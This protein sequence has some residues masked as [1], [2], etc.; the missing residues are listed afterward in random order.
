MANPFNLNVNPYFQDFND[1]DDYYQ[2]LFRPGRPIQ[3]RELNNLQYG[4]QNQI[5]SLVSANYKEGQVVVPG[6]TTYNQYYTCVQIQNNFFGIPI[7]N[8]IDQL[9]GK[10]ISG[11]SSKITA[12][13]LYVL[14]ESE[15]I[16]KNYTL[17]LQYISASSNNFS[18]RTFDDNET[19]SLV[20]ETIRYGNVTINANTPLA[21]T[22]TSQSSA[23]GSS[24]SINDGVF[25]VRNYLVRAS[26]QTILL[27]QYSNFPS[28]RIGFSVQERIVTYSEDDNLVDNALGFNNYNAPG[29]DRL[30]IN[31]TLTK[32][33]LDDFNDVSFVELA[34]VVNGVLQKLEVLEVAPWRDELA[35]RTYDESGNY[36]VKSFT[37][38]ANESVNDLTGNNGIYLP[39]QITSSGEVPSDN[40]FVYNI[41][42][43]KAYVEGYEVTK[44]ESTYLDSF[45][46]RSTNTIDEITVPFQYD[47]SLT[48]NNIDGTIPINNQSAIVEIYAERKGTVGLTTVGLGKVYDISYAN[49]YTNESSNAYIDF[50]DLQLFTFITVNQNPDLTSQTAYVTG[51][52]SGASGYLY[53]KNINTKQ[54][55]LYQTSGKFLIGESL[56]IDGVSNSRDGKI[57]NLVITDLDEYNISRIKSIRY[58][59][60][61]TG[62]FSADFLLNI[63][64]IPISLTTQYT[65]TPVSATTATITA[66]GN[67]FAAQ[68]L[69]GDIVSYSQPGNI[70]P[71]YNVVI[72]VNNLANQV[73]VANVTSVPNVCIGTVPSTLLVVNDFKV[74]RTT[75]TSDYPVLWAQLP[76]QYVKEL[77]TT[78]SVVY[79]KYQTI[80]NVV[81]GSLSISAPSNKT[82]S[83]FDPLSYS[84]TYSDG[85]NEI[86][87]P[88][89]TRVSADGLLLTF[90][91]L[92]KQSATNVLINSVV[93]NTA[94]VSKTKTLI[95]SNKI[96]VDG[97]NVTNDTTESLNLTFKS[98]FGTRIQD[99]LI[100]LN[101][102]DVLKIRGI[103]ESID[104]NDPILPSI[105]LSSLSTDIN[106]III[107]EQFRGETSLSVATV[108][109][110]DPINQRVYFTFDNDNTFIVG[111]LIGFYESSVIATINA[112][113]DGSSNIT[114]NFTFDNGQTATI[115]N[116]SKIIRKDNSPVPTNKILIVFDNYIINPNIEGSF[117]SV[118]SYEG[119]NYGTQIPTITTGRLTDIID[120]R[121]RVSPYTYNVLNQRSPFEFLART[122]STSTNS[123]SQII[124]AGES[125]VV[126]LTYYLG[127][128]DAIYLDTNGLFQIKVGTPSDTPTPPLPL[129]NAINL[130]TITLPPYLTNARE[131]SIEVS[132]YR[133][134]QMRDISRLET[135][136]SNLEY[137]TNLSLLESTTLS[138]TIKDPLTGLDRFKSGFF[139]DNFRSHDVQ[140][141][142]NVEFRA[143]SD[144]LDGTLRPS[145][146]TTAID[147]V[148]GSNSIL[149]IG[150]IPASQV[151][152]SV[153][154][155]DLIGTNI[156]KTGDLLTLSY[157]E[158]LFAQNLFAT[159]VENV[160]PFLVVDY[161]GEVVL[162]PNSD[163]WI[164]TTA[165]QPNDI[166]LE[167]DYQALLDQFGADAQTGWAPIDWKSWETN[168]VGVNVSA[169]SSTETSSSSSS[170]NTGTGTLNSTTQTSVTTSTVSVGVDLGQTR[171]GTQTRITP[172]IETADL[173]NRVVSRDLIPFMRSRNLQFTCKGMKP[174]TQHYVFF[175]NVNMTGFCVPKLVE[176][177][178]NPNSAAF[179]PGEVVIG[180]VEGDFNASNPNTIL[181]YIRARIAVA[182]H[183]YGDFLNPTEV[184]TRNPYFPE[185]ALPAAYSGNSTILNIDTES[186]QDQAQGEFFGYILSNMVLVGQTSGAVCTV[187]PPRLISDSAGSL[188]GSL[189][190]PQPN[191]VGT[192]TFLAG[193]RTLKV[194]SNSSNSPIPGD[195]DS[196]GQALFYAQGQ[197]DTTQETS[198]SIRFGDVSVVRGLTESRVISGSG[199]ATFVSGQ[200]SFT[201]TNFIPNPP[202]PPP[203]PII[204]NIIRREV[205]IVQA[206]PPRNVDPL[207]Q[208]FY[209]QEETDI[210]I[211]SVDLFFYTKDP[212]GIP[213]IV[214]LRSTN[215][216]YPTD[217]VLPFGTVVLEPDQI[218]V[219]DD[220]TVPTRFTFPSP[221]VL[222]GNGSLYALVV[223]SVSQAYNIWI[224]RMGQVDITTINKPDSEKVIVGNQP[225]TGDLFKSGNGSTWIADGYEDM[226]FRLYKAEFTA[227]AGSA[228]FYNPVLNSGN[229]QVI[230][231][232]NNPLVISSKQQILTFPTSISNLFG[233]SVY[234]Y[235]TSTEQLTSGVINAQ[236][237]DIN[238]LTINSSGVGFN[239]GV[240][241]G[242]GL[243]AITGS[244]LGGQASINVGAGGTI[245]G[246]SIQ[247]GGSGYSVNDIVSIIP[248]VDTGFGYNFEAT[249]SD[250]NLQDSMIL[251]EVNANF[252]NIDTVYYNSPSTGLPINLGVPSSVLNGD[253]D[254][255]HMQV[256]HGNHAML[257]PRNYVTIS[258]AKSLTV[259]TV[260]TVGI[261]T[262]ANTIAV[263]NASQFYIFEGREVSEDNP[264][265]LIIESEII[266]YTSV[267]ANTI[268][269][270]ITRGVDG[271]IPTPHNVG[272]K[273][274]TYQ[275]NGISLR[276]I[277]T[278][279]Q[280]DDAIEQ[281]KYYPQLDYYYVKI[282]PTRNG[283]NRSD[284]FFTVDGNFG[285]ND[286]LATQNIQFSTI[287]PNVQ[288]LT[289]TGTSI[290]TRIRPISGTS[291]GSTLLSTQPSF[292]DQ[293]YTNVTNQ[294]SN[295]L[296]RPALIASK[297]NENAF[298]TDLV[299]SK[300]FNLEVGLFSNN[301]N[302]SPC[303]DLTRVSAILTSNRLDK[304]IID[305]ASD[306]RVNILGQDPSAAIYISK[307]VTLKSPATTLEVL[308]AANRPPTS[309]FRVLYRIFTNDSR[310]E[311]QD[312]QLFPGY[313]N[314]DD[315]GRVINPRFND[316]LPD[317]FVASSTNNTFLDYQF[318]ASDIGPFTGFVIK[319]VM[320]GT[321]E[322]TPPIL[323]DLR[324]L[325]LA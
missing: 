37:I 23:S 292:I 98:A 305:F 217:F 315:L 110:T 238:T 235:N 36:Y 256:R 205:R 288:V 208:T 115:L 269:G 51:R 90:E 116:Y 9:E 283:T 16:N 273:V 291:A 325:A 97:S 274:S 181:A 293:G 304:Q 248:T 243:T 68:I 190:F 84:L 120:F 257:D 255:L 50:Y 107:G 5:N 223:K 182:N 124:K 231:L 104:A 66:V 131:L 101:V 227:E 100:S 17:Y 275:I 75:F 247:D 148:L 24:F 307:P 106:N 158:T 237:G 209:V 117:V 155:T 132:E 174:S 10:I 203:A 185:E 59:G 88:Q 129:G 206:P 149:G 204:N 48:I 282:D 58:D 179:I 77:D 270:I 54:L 160:T 56:I 262:L 73:T 41:S 13:V 222:Q 178:M 197:I 311:D 1:L 234:Q 241:L 125:I 278:T 301:K 65:L 251:S 199:S 166:N 215:N 83:P 114:K 32:K 42:A 303:V 230:K 143:S 186:L 111:E 189:F 224:S 170:T 244:G 306:N 152:L 172:R 159:K 138:V 25:Y 168:W 161:V 82:F 113:Y 20:D 35:R 162:N 265:F 95:R 264:G 53:S 44:S 194:T 277:N 76:K 144:T 276:R 150:T 299:G 126:G 296:L 286:V 316:G 2:L 78:G 192:P 103:Y 47:N 79:E 167:G 21:S 312:Y 99:R 136:I 109:E 31:L 153:N 233:L 28:Y 289:P 154:Y 12:K 254:G 18:N 322:A 38:G 258:G 40:I 8:Y 221:V 102:C 85:T 64:Y 123:S 171:T 321:N 210:Y 313:N 285:G 195:V 19:I 72:D 317:A 267:S 184:Y 323:R 229:D 236:T 284:L 225:A 67:D 198:L 250:L 320:V 43:G 119:Y 62:I 63:P 212:I 87:T 287:T 127:R 26:R 80:G 196:Q 147:L 81:N 30:Q 319:I 142:T 14:S 202:P 7:S 193:T 89:N 146:Y 298:C 34:R 164:D 279:F 263:E 183:R 70:L 213:V 175:D 259:P 207:A 108:V 157:T 122:Y 151:D 112:A 93:V 280:L 4:L 135:R 134:Y 232:R 3:A 290:A 121:P 226:T 297:V 96:V 177:Q 156:Q 118:S 308:L 27:D 128:I 246:I 253:S 252:N 188:I 272:I 91:A 6:A 39:G 310:N 191:L 268:G 11:T 92:S 15:S 281:D 29:A 86:L 22:I 71:T 33:P 260:L 105:Q 266:S 228:N 309:D 173:G 220:G 165:L 261:T 187:L 314:L 169:S 55:V 201:D 60:G 249:V 130:A 133:R 46:P 239:T 139:V 49:G 271:T 69:I 216:A 141:I 57:S 219:S 218:N 74:L 300:S 324:V 245:I 137:Y 52:N 214:E 242:V 176:I 163:T 180:E 200:S 145:H 140:D 61:S 302:I 94:V 240:Y 318:T 45:K 211:T 294:A 295:N